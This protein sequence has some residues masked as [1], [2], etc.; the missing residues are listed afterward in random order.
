MG[1]T[2]EKDRKRKGDN[3]GLRRKWG[4]DR[5]EEMVVKKEMDQKIKT[6]AKNR[7]QL[8]ASGGY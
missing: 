5:K 1:K 8:S 7:R 4:Q 6:K 2:R 3:E